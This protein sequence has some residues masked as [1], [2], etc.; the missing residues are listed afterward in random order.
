MNTISHAQRLLPSPPPQCSSLSLSVRLALVLSLPLPA[1]AQAWPTKPLRLVA[2][3]SPGSGVDLVARVIAQ[4]LGEQL[5][6]QAVVDNRAGAGGNLGA[7]VAARS[8]P[9]GY[10]LFMGT[11]AHAINA[12]LYRK[13]GYDLVR[14][15]TPVTLATT[16]HYV[17][18]VNPSVP[19]KS[20]REFVALAKARPGRLTYASAGNGNATHLA[21][22]LLRSMAGI[23]MLHVP[24]KGSGPALSDVIAGHA[25]LMFANLTAAMPHIRSGRIRALGVTGGARADSAR[26]LPTLAEAGVPGYAVSAWYGVLAPA[27]TPSEVVARLNAEIARALRAPDTRARLAGD[28]ADPAPGTPVEFARLIQSEIATWTK[29]IAQAGLKPE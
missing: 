28:G 16:G 25:D 12:A 20:V 24:Y 7:E 19:A 6:Q 4:K 13:L 17:L 3:S 2:A 23:D 27:G 22:E 18:V 14:D 5:G 11:P 26:D 21:A 9:D 15:F 29:V 10:T 8:A 1:L